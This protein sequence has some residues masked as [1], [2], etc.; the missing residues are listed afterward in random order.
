[1]EESREHLQ[2]QLGRRFPQPGS[3]TCAESLSELLSQ[4]PLILL[5]G[6]AAPRA[7]PAAP[8]TAPRSAA[9]LARATLSSPEGRGPARPGRRRL[10]RGRWPRGRACAATS[11]GL[12]VEGECWLRG[13]AT[14]FGANGPHAEA[15]VGTTHPFS[16]PGAGLGSGSGLVGAPPPSPG[17]PPSWAAMMAALYPSTDL[18]GASSSLPSSPSSSSSPNE[19]MAL[20][21]VR[22][23]KEEN[24]L[25]EKLFL[26]AC[27]KVRRC[28]FGGNRL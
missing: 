6:R 14:P 4:R 21:D 16:S 27:D 28:T 22:E 20:K 10:G 9:A 13:E 15:A 17:L 24:T 26:L 8:G 1:R 19:V 2:A 11:L 3:P 23:V 5:P 25:N 12:S 18:S 7:A